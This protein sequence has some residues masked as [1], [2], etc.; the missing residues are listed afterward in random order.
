M[1]EVVADGDSLVSL[2]R[3]EVPRF[4]PSNRSGNVHTVKNPWTGSEA[5]VIVSLIS[6]EVVLE[7]A[8]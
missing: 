7:L 8:R 3:S 5:E 4:A 1:L 6:L 2:A